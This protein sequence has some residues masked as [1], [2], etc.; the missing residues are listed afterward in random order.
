MAKRKRKTNKS[1]VVAFATGLAIVVILII[2]LILLYTGEKTSVKAEN[3]QPVAGTEAEPAVAKPPLEDNGSGN[4]I[5]TESSPPEPTSPGN[6]QASATGKTGTEAIIKKIPGKK[7]IV[8]IDDVGY[9][10]FQLEPYAGF[11]GTLTFAVLP[12]LP[13]TRATAERAVSFGAEVLLH[14]PLESISGTDTGPGAVFTRMTD[15]E[16]RQQLEIDMKQLPEAVGINNHMGS[17]ATTDGRVM[18]E[19]LAFAKGRDLLFLDSL[20]TADSVTEELSLETGVH[21]LKRNIFLDNQCG[22]DYIREAIDE[23]LASAE[24]RGYVIMIGHIWCKL[25]PV[26]L[27]EHY[28]EITAKGF[29]F[30]GISDLVQV[31]HDGSGD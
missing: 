19:I 18:K 17:L 15:T 23:G 13:Y 22:D 8:V 12:D 10:L 20:T 30:A 16:I 24:K 28:D 26:Y 21:F 5:P 14:L 29:V 25:L 7:I 6:S 1:V 11:P 9:N 3:S 31:S 2:V 27:T 4:T